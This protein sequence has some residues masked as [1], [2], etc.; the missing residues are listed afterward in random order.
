M[1][2]GDVVGDDVVCDATARVFVYVA[3]IRKR[4][5]RL[6]YYC[7]IDYMTHLGL[8]LFYYRA[9]LLRVVN[10][11]SSFARM[12]VDLRISPIISCTFLLFF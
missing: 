1:E 12:F 8:L 4:D 3:G 11:L 6:Y 10:M 5:E 7:L 9:M 2:V